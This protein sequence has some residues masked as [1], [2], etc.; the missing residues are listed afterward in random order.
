MRRVFAILCAIALLGCHSFDLGPAR[1][2]T[3]PLL[4]QASKALEAGDQLR[5]CDHLREFAAKY[6]KSKDAPTLCG[7]VLYKLAR[8][9]EARAQF[10]SAISRLD[11]DVDADLPVLVHCHG[12]LIALAGIDADEAAERLHRGIGLY[13]LSRCPSE[14]DDDDADP[15]S[16]LF[17]AIHE[18]NA[19][20][21]AAPDDARPC[22]YLHLA[23]RAVGQD[24]PAR[25]WLHECDRLARVVPTSALT[26]S[27]RRGLDMRLAEY[28]M[29]RR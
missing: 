22:W 12:R 25:R 23:W 7:E 18:L 2:A 24:G 5:A 10:E 20:H 6:P 4:T 11:D 8:Y 29:I 26:A 13:L 17:K 16:T 1:P 28:A 9:G 14:P 3:D 27:E 15:E 21:A 19:A